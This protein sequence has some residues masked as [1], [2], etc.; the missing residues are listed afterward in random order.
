MTEQSAA[1]MVSAHAE[2]LARGVVDGRGEDANRILERVQKGAGV[3]VLEPLFTC[4]AAECAKSLVF[5]LSEIGPRSV[6]AMPWINRLL[7]H[8]DE[9]VR[10]SAIVA[11]QHSGSLSHGEVTAKAVAKV[12]DIRPVALGALKLLALGSL[13]QLAT[14]TDH[15]AGDLADAIGWLVGESYE[16]QPPYLAGDGGVALV[17]VAAAYRR[18]HRDPEV[19]ARLVDD[20]RPRIADAARYIARFEPLPPEGRD[21]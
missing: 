21:V 14:A 7:D 20:P 15:L 8:R 13:R 10:H 11:L 5:I 3:G 18:R 19:L 17:G 9:Y 4:D 1:D 2:R 16:Q 6:E 12:D